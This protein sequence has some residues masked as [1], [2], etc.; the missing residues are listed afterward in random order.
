MFK[1]IALYSPPKSPEHFRRHYAE[2]HL[3]LVAK[4]PG[5]LGSRHSFTINGGESPYFCIWEGDYDSAETLQQAMASPAGQAVAADVENYATGGVVFL[6]F[7]VVEA[8]K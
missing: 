8:S 3:P 6:T 7:E 5:L 1:V 2:T 4:L